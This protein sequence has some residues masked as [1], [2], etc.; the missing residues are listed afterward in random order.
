MGVIKAKLYNF[1]DR[2]DYIPLALHSYA[3]PFSV[4]VKR[5]ELRN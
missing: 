3:Q 4:K 5:A 1:D 2:T